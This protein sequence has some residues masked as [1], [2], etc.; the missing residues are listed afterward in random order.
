MIYIGGPQVMVG[1]TRQIM[2]QNCML[3]ALAGYPHNFEERPHP[4]K[5]MKWVCFLVY[6]DSP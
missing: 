2:I 3:Q 1:D 4:P 6:Q 5:V